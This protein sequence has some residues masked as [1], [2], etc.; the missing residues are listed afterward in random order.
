MFDC[1]LQAQK[2]DVYKSPNCINTVY[3]LRAQGLK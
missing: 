2:D 1:A 3:R